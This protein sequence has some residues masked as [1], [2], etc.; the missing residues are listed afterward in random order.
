MHRVE[1]AEVVVDE[2]AHE[3]VVQRQQLAQPHRQRCAF[4]LFARVVVQR[5]LRG[6]GR[7]TVL[8][9][10]PQ[11]GA[12]QRQ[13]MPHQQAQVLVAGAAHRIGGPERG[14]DQAQQRRQRRLGGWRGG[15][16]AL[17]VAQAVRQQAVHKARQ[18]RLHDLR[19]RT[20]R[21]GHAGHTL[22]FEGAAVVGRLQLT[23]GLA[24][25]IEHLQGP[26][27]MIRHHPAAHR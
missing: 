12:H 17:A 10:Q 21:I 18:L 23:L 6:G 7:A 1:A 20:Q 26:V 24:R 14:V 8:H 5:A 22:P 11:L 4:Q 19:R 25:G 3:P 27:Q 15:L 2:V 13:R 9:L 16:Q